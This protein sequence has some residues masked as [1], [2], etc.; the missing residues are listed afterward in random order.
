M[1]KISFN[2][3]FL[4]RGLT[5]ILGMLAVVV[6]FTACSPDDF[7]GAD[8]NGVPSI[9]DAQ[10]HVDVDQNTNLVTF[11]LDT[12]GMY[13]IW[14]I[15]GSPVVKTT[16][17]GYQKKF[18][19]KGTYDFTLKVGNR[20]GVSDG[21]VSGTFTVD[22]TR[23]DF[24]TLIAH[25]TGGGTKEWR[26]SSKDKGIWLAVLMAPMARTGGRQALTRRVRTASTTTASPS[27]LT[28]STPTA[29]VTT[30]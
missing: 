28:T 11:T 22:S 15:N 4:R 14:T 8:P 25:L 19:F 16:V 21:E 9:S 26:I 1:N 5:S 24:S 29:L 3:R 2:S 27:L 13:P 18:I 17:N 7:N 10:Y 23:Y 6:A 30:A 12:P 20:N